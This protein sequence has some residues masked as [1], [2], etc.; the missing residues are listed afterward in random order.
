MKVATPP[1]S[2]P[3]P[4]GLPPSRNVTVPVGVPAPDETVAVKVTDCPKTEGLLLEATVVEVLAWLTVS[5]AEAVLPA[6]LSL[7]VIV[8]VV[9]FCIPALMPVTFT[10]KLHPPVAAKAAPERLMLFEPAA[11]VMVPPPH[12]PVSPLGFATT[13]PAGSVSLNP[14]PLREA[15]ALGLSI[16]NLREV[17]PVSGIVDAPKALAMVGGAKPEMVLKHA[18]TSFKVGVTVLSVVVSDAWY[19]R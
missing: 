1:L 10:A 12:E 2:V 15:L 13:N 6:P 19:L 14:I 11:A 7:E 17:V 9:L 8:P 16:V 5:E 4:I 3:V 18:V